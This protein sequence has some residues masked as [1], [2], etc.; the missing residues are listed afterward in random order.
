MKKFRVCLLLL[1][2][3]CL[4]CGAASAQSLKDILNSGTL[5]DVVTSV[6]GGK[7]PTA[8]NIAGTWVYTG[9]ALQLKGDNA[10]KNIAGSVGT[11]EAEKKIKEYCAKI[12]IEEG[13][14]DYAFE[15]DGTFT[16]Q[17]KRAKLKGTY[18]VDAEAKTLELNYTVG[19]KKLLALTADVLLTNKQLTLLFHADKLLDFLEKVSSV[20]DNAAFQAVNKLASQYDGLMLGFDLQKQ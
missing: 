19:K 13:M 14:F 4:G 5:K 2:M 11:A 20:S 7:K 3:V 12:G 6:T 17:L 8:E 9:P 15:A 18:A 1:G 16:S 10:F